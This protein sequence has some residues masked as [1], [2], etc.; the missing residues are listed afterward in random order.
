MGASTSTCGLLLGRRVSISR[1]RSRRNRRDERW[2]G[3]RA[4]S[5]NGWYLDAVGNL[6]QWEAIY[7]REPLTN[8]SCTYGALPRDESCTCSCPSGPWRDGRCVRAAISRVCQ[9]AEEEGGVLH[10]LH[11]MRDV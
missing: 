6:N 2:K 3:Y 11:E 4:L 10:G 9:I 5:T 1:A 8:K 7:T